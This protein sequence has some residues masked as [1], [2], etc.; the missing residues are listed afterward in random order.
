[1]IAEHQLPERRACLLVRLSRECHRSPR[2]AGEYIQL[3]GA[4][5]VE[6]AQVDCHFG[7]RLI[8][9]LLRPEFLGVKSQ[10]D[11]SA[12]QPGTTGG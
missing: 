1:M 8:H 3:L 12:V 10:A 6:I 11:I 2:L 5:I 4:K 7:S 9:D